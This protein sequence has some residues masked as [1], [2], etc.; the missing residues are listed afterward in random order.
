MQ[1]KKKEKE[2]CYDMQ[3]FTYLEFCIEMKLD[4]IR[5]IDD[6]RKLE[7]FVKKNEYFL[8]SSSVKGCP[9]IRLHMAMKAWK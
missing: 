7:K 3:H 8:P 1:G 9:K 6:V 5:E 4:F 2:K